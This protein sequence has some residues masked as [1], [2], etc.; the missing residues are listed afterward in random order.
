LVED[1]S[2][3]TFS[4]NTLQ[5][6]CFTTPLWE[7]I[8]I[9]NNQVINSSNLVINMRYQ[10]AEGERLNNFSV[11][12]HNEN[13]G[14]IWTSG[15]IGMP[16]R[17]VQINGLSNNTIYY[18][19]ARG[20]T[21]N[22]ML[23]DTLLIGIRTSYIIPD[24][25]KYLY[26]TNSPNNA[27]VKM[28]I[29]TTNINLSDIDGIL[30]KRRIKGDFNWIN[31]Y[32]LNKFITGLNIYERF[33]NTVRSKTNYE[34]GGCVTK[35]GIEGT[36]YIVEITP[37]FNG[38]FIMGKDTFFNTCMNVD[39]NNQQ[40]N[41]D[42]GVFKPLGRRTPVVISN[43][44]SN[45]KS[46][47]ISFL[48]MTDIDNPE[49]SWEDREKLNNF[50]FDGSI[51][52]LKNST[53]LAKMISVSSSQINEQPIGGH[54]DIISTAFEWVEVGDINNADDLFNTGFINIR[55]DGSFFEEGGVI[56]NT[57]ILNLVNVTLLR[58]IDDNINN[59]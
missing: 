32:Y 47:N 27:S 19:R 14:Q 22:G 5:F 7:F 25:D 17:T 13:M 15:I 28:T 8:D 41:K 30:V 34:Y 57:D 55:N 33:D 39:I 48:Y 29:D 44:T 21:V 51:K 52:L 49:K 9:I 20:T 16:L 1:V 4:S 54:P 53:G 42:S 37:C 35:D 59:I 38:L 3:N 24:D 40:Q 11:S 45:F 23:I 12:L 50:I 26:V 2:N 56:D 58:I 46:G 10:Q 36:L 6:R 43:G 18:I 31:I